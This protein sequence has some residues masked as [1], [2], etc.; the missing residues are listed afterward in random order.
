M[1]AHEVFEK[2]NK[3]GVA[4]NLRTGQE[5]REVPDATHVSS[6]IEMANLGLSYNIAVIDEIQMIADLQRGDSW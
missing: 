1:L 6:T 3:Q 4:T 2:L 5:L